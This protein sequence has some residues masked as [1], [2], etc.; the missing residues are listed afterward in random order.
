MFQRD[1]IGSVK[2]TPFPLVKAFLPLWP[3]PVVRERRARLARMALDL[4]V[5]G[6]WVK[7][8]RMSATEQPSNAWPLGWLGPAG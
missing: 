3:L 4:W 1:E 5:P 8:R 7:T 2:F 6:E